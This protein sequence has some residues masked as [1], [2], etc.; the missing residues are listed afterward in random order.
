M[1]TAGRQ[2]ARGVSGAAKSSELTGSGN[3]QLEHSSSHHCSTHFLFKKNR[4]ALANVWSSSS[5]LN[6]LPF[7][8]LLLLSSSA[9]V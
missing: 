5:I 7:W 4:R 6:V 1:R 9:I 2:T 3:N 8:L